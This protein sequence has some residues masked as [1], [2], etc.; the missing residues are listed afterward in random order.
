MPQQQ[1]RR[2]ARVAVV[3]AGAAGLAAARELRDE[4]HTAV[5]FEASHAIGGTWRYDAAPGVH[6]SMYANL[7]TNLPRELMG[8]ADLPF[9]SATP[10]TGDARRYCGHAEVQAY[11]ELF[12]A[13]NALHSL[14]RFGVRVQRA[15][16][17]WEGATA[18]GPRWRVETSAACEDSTFDALLVANGHYSE[19]R[20]LHVPGAADFPGSLQHTH[21]YRT[22][23]PFAGK[24]VV[25]VGAASSGEDVSRDI[26][27]VAAATFLSAASFMT[28]GPIASGAVQK[29]AL[30]VRLHADGAA[31]FAD[32]T[33]EAVDVVLF[34]T[35]YHFHFPFL[36]GA[37][38]CAR[39]RTLVAVSRCR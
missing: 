33:R 11:L 37:C 32:G 5:V 4:G 23:A 30:L 24:R 36:E 22:P 28:E 3:G 26:A 39:A 27:P 20:T 31:E 21:D 29:R 10:L 1:P 18:L 16:P 13:R 15:T 34:A 9:S 8:F 14:I 38:A 7:R 12:A 2:S 19:P 35:G 6:S 17:L 25:V